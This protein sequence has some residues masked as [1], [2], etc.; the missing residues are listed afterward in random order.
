MEVLNYLKRNNGSEHIIEHVGFHESGDYLLR[1]LFSESEN[2]FRQH[3]YEVENEYDVIDKSEVVQLKRQTCM[4]R[5]NE[6]G[7]QERNENIDHWK[8]YPNG[9]RCCSY[10][11]SLHPEDV[12]KKIKEHGFGVIGQTTKNYKFYVGTNASVRTNDSHGQKYY[13]QHDTEEF[14][15]QWNELIDKRKTVEK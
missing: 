11:G 5:M 2:P 8:V 15:Q 9:D 13:R 10:C 1:Q 12:I 7:G 6:F 4:R 3:K 14:I